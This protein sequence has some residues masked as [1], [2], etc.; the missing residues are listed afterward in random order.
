MVS[1]TLSTHSAQWAQ[2]AQK[3][4]CQLTSWQ[5]HRPSNHLCRYFDNNGLGVLGLLRDILP[6]LLQ[7]FE[8]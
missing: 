8:V 6:T 2:M 5:E 1:V 7:H 4:R 3:A